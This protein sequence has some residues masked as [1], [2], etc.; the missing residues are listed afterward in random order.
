LLLKS[1]NLKEV[2]FHPFYTELIPGYFEYS[3][4]NQ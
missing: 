2:K 3:N 4:V 1:I